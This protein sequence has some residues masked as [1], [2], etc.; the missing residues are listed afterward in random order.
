MAEKTR[1]TRSVGN[2]RKKPSDTV[3]VPALKTMTPEE[4]HQY[5]DSRLNML[6]SG[7]TPL[8]VRAKKPRQQ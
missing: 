3:V 5:I 6:S 4:L 8:A 2:N 7:R 1:R